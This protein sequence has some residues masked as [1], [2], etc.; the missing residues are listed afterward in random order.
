MPD[1]ENDPVTDKRVAEERARR[2]ML[3][4][5]RSAEG[6]GSA[7]THGPSTRPH[8]GNLCPECARAYAAQEGDARED[9]IWDEIAS[10]CQ[11]AWPKK[12][13]AWS[14]SPIELIVQIIDE[15]DALQR[16][17][18]ALTELLERVRCAEDPEEYLDD[19]EAAL[20]GGGMG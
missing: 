13:L 17:V 14:Q 12:T 9:Q 7:C 6:W 4:E 8:D 11:Q 19:V 1:L 15:R 2:E 16:R 20:R 5:P 18:E 3:P 10:V